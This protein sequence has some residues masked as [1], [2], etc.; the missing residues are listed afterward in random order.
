MLEA[1]R[2]WESVVLK[3]LVCPLCLKLALQVYHLVLNWKISFLLFLALF[4][5]HLLFE[6]EL[7]LELLLYANAVITTIALDYYSP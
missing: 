7:K 4:L 3:G 2:I 6:D 1:D 5:H